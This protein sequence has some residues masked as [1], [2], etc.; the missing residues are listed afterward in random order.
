MPVRRLIVALVFMLM[1]GVL[2]S[3]V[4]ANPSSPLGGGQKSDSSSCGGGTLVVNVNY[5]IINNADSG[6]NGTWAWDA[7][8]RSLQIWQTGLDTYCAATRDSGKFTTIA[9]QTSPGQDS[10]NVLA[11][12]V[13]GS[14]NGGYSTTEFTGTLNAAPG[15]SMRGNLGTIDYQCEVDP[16]C[17]GAFHW[18]SVYFTD[19]SDSDFGLNWWGWTYKY[20]SQTWV[21]G[22]DG[23]SGDITG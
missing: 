4:L 19:V 8:N 21:N 10:T 3:V 11:A 20:R 7:F 17:P 1:V 22:A 15:L 14:M 12:A 2:P 16:S 18:W 6:F 9:G 23:S 13:T 5:Y